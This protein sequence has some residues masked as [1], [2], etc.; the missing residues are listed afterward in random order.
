MGVYEDQ[1]VGD[2]F[3]EWK[4]ICKKGPGVGV[5]VENDGQEG[6]RRF[7]SD[8]WLDSTLEMELSAS[9]D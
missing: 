1:E 3:G 7:Y 5:C 8:D 2:C 9:E 6:W 4:S